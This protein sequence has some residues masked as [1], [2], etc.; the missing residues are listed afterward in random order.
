MSQNIAILGAG[1]S[2]QAARRLAEARGH[3]TCVFDER[4]EGDSDAFTAE[5]CEAFDS[6]VISPGF[7]HMHPWRQIAAESSKSCFGEIGFA[8]QQW[9]GKLIAVTGTNGKSTITKFL[10]QALQNVGWKA[11]AT[12]NIGYPLSDAVLS[13]ANHPDGYAILEVSSFQAELPQGL[14]IDWLIWTNFAEDHLDRYDSMAEY[15]LAKANL[16]GCLTAAGVCVISPQVRD[17]M[18]LMKTDF[19][20]CSVAHRNV[21][22]S[23]LLSLGSTFQHFPQSDNFSLD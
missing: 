11:V 15:F 3:A 2:G 6:I 16:L 20:T 10:A 18:K 4:G 17:W 8:A 21:D 9:Q 12:G 1:I 13:E 5:V 7:A 19:D 23:A 14:E 22:Q